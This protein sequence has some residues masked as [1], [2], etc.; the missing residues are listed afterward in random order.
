[1]KN[2]LSFP[3]FRLRPVLGLALTL[4]LLNCTK[5]PEKVLP[6]APAPSAPVTG[7]EEARDYSAYT[8]LAW[9]DE[10]NGALLDDTKWT[11]EIKDVW[12][13][14]ELQA[15]T[16]SAKNLFLSNGLLNI[17][18][19]KERYNNRDYTSARIITKGKKDFGFGRLDVRA[20][21]PKGKGIWPA[22][23]MLGSNDGVVSWPA[24]GEID[25]MELRGS[26]PNVNISTLHFGTSVADHREKTTTKALASGDF[27][28]D[29]HTFT[30]IRSKD[31]MRFYLDGELY[32][33]VT[34]SDVSPYPFNNLF[35]VIL[36]VAVGGKFDGDP[37]AST[38][39]PQRMQ[40]E[41]V[42]FYNYK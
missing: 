6:P 23:W 40:V 7:N 19:Q 41:S 12:F 4:G 29:F 30:L 38:V 3:R 33:T 17:Q 20:K 37:D 13:N 36:N 16:N 11:Y 27:S 31:K 2:F 25:I 1:M 5:D 14:D 32:F 9:S 28:D 18:A 15:T 8:D 39:F 21:L 26:Q 10:F 22:I 34:P 35:Y 24:C 42:K